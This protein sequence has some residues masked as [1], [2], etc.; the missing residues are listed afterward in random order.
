MLRVL[1]GQ[2]PAKAVIKAQ[3]D[4][5][6]KSWTVKVVKKTGEK[7]NY[8]FTGHGWRKFVEDCGL[9]AGEFLVFKLVSN[10]VFQIVRFGLNGCVKE[11]ITD[12]VIKQETCVSEQ[13]KENHSA[14]SPKSKEAP[15]RN[16][17]LCVCVLV[18][19]TGPN[20]LF[21]LYF[22]IIGLVPFEI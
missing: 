2:V 5:S 7:Y 16:L 21:D 1:E 3:N 4:D 11:L 12:P 14:P 13:I 17:S 18:F 22:E 9:K 10:S 8:S 20:R 19:K 15:P 6:K